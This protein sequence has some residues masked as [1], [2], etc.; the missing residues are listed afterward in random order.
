[1]NRSTPTPSIQGH[2]ENHQNNC[3]KNCLSCQGLCGNY[4]CCGRCSCCLGHSHCVGV[5]GHIHHEYGYGYGGFH[6]FYSI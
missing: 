3:R 5:M 6:H 1:M 4:C 2:I